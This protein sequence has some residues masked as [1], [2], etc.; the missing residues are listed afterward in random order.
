MVGAGLQLLGA[1]PILG[2]RPADAKTR[3][4][5][6]LPQRGLLQLDDRRTLLRLVLPTAFV[7]LGAG[8]TIPFLN[9]YIEGRFGV[10]YA[11]LGRLFA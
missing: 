8:A 1:L 2:L 5:P 10:S 9:V 11:S 3:V 4:S 6:A 7:G